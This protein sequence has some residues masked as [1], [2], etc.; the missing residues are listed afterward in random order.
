VPATAT[1]RER[2]KFLKKRER[3]VPSLFWDGAETVATVGTV[4]WQDIRPR[5][6]VDGWEKAAF[7]TENHEDRRRLAA[8]EKEAA[9]EAEETAGAADEQEREEI[10]D[11]IVMR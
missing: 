11:A 6:V 8:S 5:V 1:E 3:E 7:W 4:A 10:D 2:E 9:V